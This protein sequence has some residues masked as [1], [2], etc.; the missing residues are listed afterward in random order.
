MYKRL[1]NYKTG[2]SFV[3]SNNKIIKDK[4]ILLWI[5]SLHIP[6]VYNDVVISANKDNKILAYGYDSK[7][8]KQI[9]YNPKYVQEQQQNRYKKIIEHHEVFYN[10]IK[11]ISKDMKDPMNNIKEKAIIIYL[12]INCGFRIGNKKYEKENKSFGIST[13]KF[14][15]INFINNKI[16][17]DF[18][19]KKGVRN[20][21]ECHNS[22]IYNYLKDK[23]KNHIETDDVFTNINSKDVNE[24]LKQFHDD[25][26]CKDIRTW[27]ANLMFLEYIK[28]AINNDIK[29]P[30]KYA[31]DNV[32]ERLHNT[33]TVCKKSY[34]DPNLIKMMEEKIKND[35]IKIK[36]MIN[37]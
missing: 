17:F 32:S 36:M 30:I 24:Y 13:I 10:L 19:G 5:K 9:I 18:I 33:S 29:K 25:I 14:K 2:F 6:P 35:D 23:S 1:G 21:A 15:H 37:N 16:I 31:I 34:I 28:E 11:Q 7:R 3:N 4:N 8:R 27:C 12:I 22:E 26:T 20:I